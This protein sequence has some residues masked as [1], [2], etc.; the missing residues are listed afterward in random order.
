[1]NRRIPQAQREGKKLMRSLIAVIVIVAAASTIALIEGVDAIGV[2][3][4]LALVGA[5]LLLLWGA[6]NL[7]RS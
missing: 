6:N 3:R 7:F 4:A 1:M 5:G 2:L